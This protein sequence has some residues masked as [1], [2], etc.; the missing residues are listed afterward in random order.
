MCG[1]RPVIFGEVLFDRFEDGAVV[2]GGAAFNV[3]WNLAAFGL[4]PR[5]VS[6]V[7]NDESGERVRH[8]MERW[9][10]DTADLQVDPRRPTG[11]VE[12]SLDGGSPSFT[13]L[14]DQ[15]YDEI[16]PPRVDGAISVVYHGTL[17]VRTSVSRRALDALVAE[18]GAPLFVDVN[19]RDPWWEKSA[20]QN[21]L[22]RATWAKLNDDEI[23]A[24]AEG[25]DLEAQATELQARCG[26][27]VVFLT[28]G[29]E[30]SV[31]RTPDGHTMTHAPAT[32]VAVVDTVGAGDAYTAVV[33]WGLV[34][35]WSLAETQVRAQEF[36][37]QVV[38]IRGAT[39]DRRDFYEPFLESW[40]TS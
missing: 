39:C 24:L 6:R 17:S 8:A 38:G 9:G 37:S 25:A 15:A 18:A 10:L 30:G 35:G 31:V 2:L 16:E 22:R 3:A 29:S 4:E 28:R 20:V 14:P 33:L 32:D 12:V 34:R 27:D 40:R 11:A 19:L 21:L 13:V 5:F 23:A 7:G 1:G 26:L 36:A